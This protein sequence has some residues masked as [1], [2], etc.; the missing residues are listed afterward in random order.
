[1][2]DL[3]FRTLGAWGAGKGA[4]LDA[5]EVDANFWSLAEAIVNLQNNPA[6]PVGIASIGISGS[7]MTITLTDGS[8]MGP[9]TIPVLTFRWRGEYEPGIYAVLDVF[10]VTSGNA[11][12]DPATVRYGIFMVQVAG[13]YD[14]FDPTATDIDGNPVY[15]QLFGSVDTLLSTLGD[16]ALVPPGGPPVDGDVLVWQDSTQKWSNETLGDM[17]F[18]ASTNVNIQ[19]GQITGM[20]SPVNPLDVANKAYVDALPAGMTAPSGTMMAN[21]TGT[22]AAAVPNYLSD[23]L[24]FALGTTVRGTLIYR[25]SPGWIA[26]PPGTSGYFLQTHGAGADPAWSVGGSGVTSV[27]AGAGISTGGAPITGTGSVALATISSGYV[28]SNISGSVA[29]P[30]PN[31]LTALLDALVGNVRGSVAYRGGTVWTALPPDSAGKYLKTQGPGV[32]PTWDSPTGAGT[33]TSVGT[34]TGLTGGPVTS[35]GTIALAQIADAAFL[36]NISGASAA[37]L[38]VTLT[39]FLDHIFASSAQGSVIYRGASAYAALGPGT[40]GQVL[41]TGG[42]SANPSW[43]S[44]AGG[45]AIA[46]HYL[47]ANLSGSTAV[48]T[49]HSLSDILDYDVGST[50]GMLLYRSS[51]GW[52]ALAPGT[53]GQVLTTGGSSADPAWATGGSISI[54]DTPPASPT[55][56]QAWFDSGGGQLYIRYNDGTS[57]QWVPATNT[58]SIGNYLPLSGGTISGT[59]P[60]TLTINANAAALANPSAGTLL[61]LQ[62]VDATAN[63]VQLN[64]FGSNNLILSQNSGG[65]AAAPTAT[66]GALMT[67]GMRG[68]DTTWTGQAAQISVS[69]ITSP[70]TTA[71]HSTRIIFNTTPVGSTVLATAATIASGLT[72][73]TPLAS[74]ADNGRGSLICNANTVTAPINVGFANQ[75]FLSMGPDGGANNHVIL[76]FNGSANLNVMRANNTAGA[77]ATLTATQGIGRINAGGWDGTAWVINGPGQLV[78]T[79][80]ETWSASAHGTIAQVQTTPNGSITPAVNLTLDGSGNLT[81]IGGT[82]TKAGGG[83]WVAPS[84]PAL[85]TDVTPYTDGLDAL[86]QLQPVRYA[87]NGRAGTPDDGRQYVG[88]DAE[89]AAA[90]MPSLVGEMTYQPHAPNDEGELVP[91]GAPETYKTVDPSELVF[92]L[93]NAVR[94][95]SARIEALEAG[96]D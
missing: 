94:E 29:A 16:V 38:P 83:S 21:I 47:L 89:A 52:V 82:A 9:F 74:G 63:I 76:A 64:A 27:A 66:T 30:T 4:N 85:K 46:D 28:L 88:L 19:G 43:A 80:N 78:F 54:G 37:P 90:T 95:L 6:Q 84:D 35:A 2:V 17:A 32:D 59:S 8:V 25:G 26:L 12:I 23:Y 51:T 69:T 56:G 36:G 34:G 91:E 41:T 73:G 45:A 39:Q 93:L 50:R 77:P 40:S 22:V 71:D 70:W 75:I 86:L 44:G 15:L 33:V 18:Q 61:R 20:S 65:T 11:S 42:A 13:T 3:T 31:T 68:Y 14:L 1:M 48:A 57:T 24:D 62:Q 92:T 55:V 7:Q 67:F 58:T 5:G 72:L 49:G 79:A 81:I 53:T 87:Y 10:T 60:G 96:D